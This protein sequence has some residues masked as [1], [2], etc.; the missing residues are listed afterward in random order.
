MYLAKLFT[1]SI[2]A[3]QFVPLFLL[4]T[5]YIHAEGPKTLPVFSLPDIDGKT[6]SSNQNA[7]K[8]VLIDFWATWCNTCKE[9]IPKLAE[10]HE[11]YKD[12]NL[13]VVGI[14][15]DKGSAEKIQKKAKRLGITYQI[16]LD[17]QSSLSKVFGFTG[18]PSLYVYDKQGNLQLGLPGYSPDQEK[19]LS[20]VV[21][22][23]VL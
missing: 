11:K 15:L 23:A 10:L 21:A 7:G 18:I 12:K 1:T 13:V 8:V 20:E 9:T 19:K 16:L 5:V 14:S 22:K 2:K 17:P 4:C 3:I 6:W